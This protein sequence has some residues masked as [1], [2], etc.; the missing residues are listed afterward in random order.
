MLTDDFDKMVSEERELKDL[1]AEKQVELLEKRRVLGP[2]QTEKV[3]FK[4]ENFARRFVPDGVIW[5]DFEDIKENL[6]LLAELDPKAISKL[7]DDKL[8]SR[9]PAV[10]Y[11]VEQLLVSV[12]NPKSDLWV[13]LKKIAD[14]VKVEGNPFIGGSR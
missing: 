8:F 1:L 6:K 14:T 5:E 12:L 10:K 13:V 4:V 3:V 7:A 9:G 2:P 11:I